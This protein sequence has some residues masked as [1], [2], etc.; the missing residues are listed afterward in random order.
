MQNTRK[1]DFLKK[2]HVYVKDIFKTW[3]FKQATCSC[4]LM[5]P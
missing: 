4:D 1:S 2:T 3:I 5:R